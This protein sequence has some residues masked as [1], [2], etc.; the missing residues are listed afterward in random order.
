[1]PNF[2]VQRLEFLPSNIRRIASISQ[3]GMREVERINKQQIDRMIEKA[4]RALWVIGGKP[5]GV[6]GL[7][8]K[9]NTDDVCFSSADWERVHAVMARP[10]VL[11]GRNLLK[12]RC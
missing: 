2:A 4:R 6:L 9:P 10:L 12:G 11:D 8:F 3:E 5:I 1:M 7:A